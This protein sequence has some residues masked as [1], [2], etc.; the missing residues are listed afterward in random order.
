M[1]SFIAH[2]AQDTS[3]GYSW[4]QQ[5]NGMA[6]ILEHR[7]FGKSAPLNATD[8]TTQ[9]QKF[10]FLTLDNVM[11]DAAGFLGYLKKN[12]T[13]ALESKVIVYSGVYFCLAFTLCCNLA[14]QAIRIIWWLPCH[15]LPS[16]PTQRLLRSYCLCTAGRFCHCLDRAT[17]L[18]MTLRIRYSSMML[19]GRS[20]W[21]QYEG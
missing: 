13:G 14:Y 7:Y 10:E 17:S 20:S 12:I 15:S 18:S 2:Q 4:A 11:A 21:E 6:V 5:T 9:S 8:P 19:A 16:K 1:R 3:I